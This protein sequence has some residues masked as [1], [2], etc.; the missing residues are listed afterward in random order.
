MVLLF[1]TTD[2]REDLAHYEIHRANVCKGVEI[3]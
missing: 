1:N 3:C 2:S